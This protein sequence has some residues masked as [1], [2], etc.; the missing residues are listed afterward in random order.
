MVSWLI[1]GDIF[2]LHFCTLS[3]VLAVDAMTVNGC[4]YHGYTLGSLL[5]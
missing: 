1:T 5:P 3:C 4:H 2:D